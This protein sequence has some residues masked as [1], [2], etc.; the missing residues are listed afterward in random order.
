M[1]SINYTIEFPVSFKNGELDAIGRPV[2]VQDEQASTSKTDKKVNVRPC[3][4]K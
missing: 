4:E 2:I 3:K 1:K